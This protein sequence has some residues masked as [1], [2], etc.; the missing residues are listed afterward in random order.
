MEK[1]S[2]NLTKEPTEPFLELEFALTRTDLFWYNLHFNRHLPVIA[3]CLLLALV[4][5]IYFL[6]VSAGDD[7]RLWLFWL[8]AGIL[9]GIG[10]CT[11][12]LLIIAAQVFYSG[13]A[14]VTVSLEPRYYRI[15]RSGLQVRSGDKQWRRNWAEIGKIHITKRAYYLFTPG[16]GSIII[17]KNRLSGEKERQT[18]IGLLPPSR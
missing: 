10:Y 2:R 4:P 5:V 11:G 7:S 16:R 14:A 9:L 8:L 6:A 18:L 13:S 17:P 3:L 15:D 12:S 1:D